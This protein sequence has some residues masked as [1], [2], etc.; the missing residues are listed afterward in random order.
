MIMQFFLII[1][2]LHVIWDQSKIHTVSFN[3]LFYLLNIIDSD[4]LKH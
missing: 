3:L 1:Y 2:A 4:N